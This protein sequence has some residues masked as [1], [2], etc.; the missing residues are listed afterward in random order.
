MYI[1]IPHL[2]ESPKVTHNRELEEFLGGEIHCQNFIN[3]DLTFLQPS[4]M[5]TPR[6]KET[7]NPLERNTIETLP[8]ETS[9]NIPIR[10]QEN[11][12]QQ[13][14][15]VDVIYDRNYSTNPATPIQPVEPV[16]GLTP[17]EIW[18]KEA[19]PNLILMDLLG[20]TSCTEHINT[21]LQTLDGLCV[22]QPSRFLPLAQE[23]KKLAKKLKEEEA[24]QW[25]G[26]PPE[27]LLNQSFVEQ[28]DYI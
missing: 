2:L 5:Q 4:V 14:S 11:D 23:A 19:D 21:P 13:P 25:S 6:P 3:Q 20:F 28:L 1:N 27:K 17:K 24:S 26:I 10:E 7:K 8:I 12:L 16:I 18:K 15:V 9:E 22:K